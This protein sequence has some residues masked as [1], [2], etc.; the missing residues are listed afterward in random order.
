MNNGMKILFLSRW[1][2]YPPDNGSRI[3]VLNLIRGLAKNHEVDLISFAQDPVE[4]WQIEGIKQYCHDVSVEKYERRTPTLVEAVRGYVT[5]MPRLFQL[6]IN[7]SIKE[8]VDQ[9]D[10]SGKYDLVLA[11]QIEMATYASSWE[12][13]KKVLEEVELAVFF[14]QM[15]KERN[16][17]RRFRNFLTWSKMK[18]YVN[19]EISRFDGCTVV[20]QNELDLLNSVKTNST[21]VILIPNGV[22]C[23]HYRGEYG[24]RDPNTL[25]YTGSL[26]YFANY[27]AVKAFI[28]DIF[29]IIRRRRPEIRFLITGSTRGVNLTGIEDVEGVY[30]TGYLPD[31]RPAIGQ[32]AV[33]VVPITVGG[34]TRL[35]IL[36]ALAIGTPVVA[37]SKGAEGLDLIDQEHILI[38]DEPEAFAEQVIF[39]LDH[40][41]EGRKLV[42]NSQKLLDEKYDWNVIGCRLEQ[43][44]TQ[45][46]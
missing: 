3:R 25:I 17:I 2:P 32:A 11:S 39:L 33:N 9:A 4:A 42:R 27:E 34:G 36:E 5:A 26:T 22:D 28:T 31:I 46:V 6:S 16:V 37:T 43:F 23:Q 40:P 35:K 8:K 21:P 30:L 29:P 45:L 1:F 13:S 24:E 14:E 44:L 10:Q 38:A 18:N 15:V 20:S 12:S 7:P 19:W 41:E